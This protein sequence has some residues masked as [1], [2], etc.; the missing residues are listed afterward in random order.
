VR[1]PSRV[2]RPD[3]VCV[4]GIPPVSGGWPLL[5]ERRAAT[6]ASASRLPPGHPSSTH[7]QAASLRRTSLHQ[8]RTAQRRPPSTLQR[9]TLEQ[10][11]SQFTLWS[12]LHSHLA[13]Q[14]P[15]ED[16]LNKVSQHINLLEGPHEDLLKEGSQ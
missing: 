12:L 1:S 8:N 9:L 7:R 16:L 15:H 2:R 5:S 3:V 4:S 10:G 13:Y 6:G 14:G 11:T